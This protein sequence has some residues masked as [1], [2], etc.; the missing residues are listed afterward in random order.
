MAKFS[1]RCGL[2]GEWFFNSGFFFSRNSS[3]FEILPFYQLLFKISKRFYRPKMTL[4]LAIF[5]R[6]FCSRIVTYWNPFLVH[7]LWTNAPLPGPPKKNL[8]DFMILNGGLCI[9]KNDG[10]KKG[11]LVFEISSIWNMKMVNFFFFDMPSSAN[12]FSWVLNPWAPAAWWQSPRWYMQ[13]EAKTTAKQKF[14]QNW[15]QMSNK[16]NFKKFFDS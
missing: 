10:P 14:D 6:F 11:F 15:I 16:K 9:V 4:N 5:V 2:L 3:F 12:L 13:G 1:G 8:L 7:D